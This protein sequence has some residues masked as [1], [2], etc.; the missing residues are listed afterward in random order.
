MKKLQP[1][2][3]ARSA[4]RPKRSEKNEK[5]GKMRYN[6]NVCFLVDDNDADEKSDKWYVWLIIIRCT[7]ISI[8]SP[9]EML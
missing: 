7:G 3:E 2:Y 4:G 6:R 5:T 9:E 1:V 8:C